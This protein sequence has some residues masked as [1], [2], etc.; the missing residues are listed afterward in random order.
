MK[1]M[2]LDDYIITDSSVLIPIEEF[3]ELLKKLKDCQ[4]DKEKLINTVNYLNKEIE[5]YNEMKS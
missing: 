2:I 3:K 5:N 1:Q 4:K